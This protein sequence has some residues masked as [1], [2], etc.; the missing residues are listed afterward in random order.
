MAASAQ[1]VKWPCLGSAECHSCFVTKAQCHANGISSRLFGIFPVQEISLLRNCRND[2]GYTMND[3]EAIGVWTES[4]R[5]RFAQVT[6]SA[7][8]FTLSTE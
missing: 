4:E 7:L 3:E 5:I 2:G 8:T 6:S 1:S